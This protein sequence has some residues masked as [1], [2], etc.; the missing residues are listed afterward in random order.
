MNPKETLA[1]ASVQP[2]VRRIGGCTQSPDADDGVHVGELSRREADGWMPFTQNHDPSFI[3]A[4]RSAYR[5]G[6]IRG[7][8]VRGMNPPNSD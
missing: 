7:Y 6:F 4:V 3:E 5:E 1:G 2:V 8:Y